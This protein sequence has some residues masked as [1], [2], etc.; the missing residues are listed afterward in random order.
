MVILVPIG[1]ATGGDQFEFELWKLS[2][3]EK[4]TVHTACRIS[5]KAWVAVSKKI[6]V[7]KSLRIVP[8]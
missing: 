2:F 8:F 3:L 5:E 1:T 6:A 7:S 4:V